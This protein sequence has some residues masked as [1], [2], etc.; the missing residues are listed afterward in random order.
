LKYFNSI[1]TDKGQILTITE[2]SNLTQTPRADYYELL[3]AN[4]TLIMLEVAKTS[5]SKVAERLHIKA[6]AFSG[7]YSCIVAHNTLTKGN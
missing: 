3:L 4:S 2:L 5:K 1:I 7:V 6:S